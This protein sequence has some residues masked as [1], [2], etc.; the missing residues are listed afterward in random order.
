MQKIKEVPMQQA[1]KFSDMVCKFNPHHDNK[2]LFSSASSSTFMT[3][4]T[5]NPAKQHLADKAIAR[6]KEKN[7]ADA[8]PAKTTSKVKEKASSG[9]KA[10]I[11][12][13]S[14]AK[15]SSNQKSKTSLETKER[16]EIKGS[17][18]EKTLDKAHKFG[19]S[20]SDDWQKSL[21]TKEKNAVAEYKSDSSKI[22]SY[23]RGTSNEKPKAA[24]KKSIENIDAAMKKASLK[25][26]AV[27]HRVVTNEFLEQLGGTKNIKSLIGKKFF[28]KAY[29]STSLIPNNYS[30]SVNIKINAKKGTKGAYVEDI[31]RD[32]T[33]QW[34][35]KEAEVLLDRNTKF[36]IVAAKKSLGKTYLE[37]NIL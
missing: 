24:L 23:L 27:L 22:N 10:K 28:D 1:V 16:F 18:T 14:K 15:V 13:E 4:Q 7:K 8:K 19:I 20:D 9:N 5:K 25:Q 31:L 21:S 34:G 36:E 12:T 26:D 37:V 6:A 33:L 3:T 29:T 2:G 17:R 11:Q 35:G 30:G 32:G